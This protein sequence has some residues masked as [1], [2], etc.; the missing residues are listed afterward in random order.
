[1]PD[2]KQPSE[3]FESNDMRLIVE[4]ARQAVEAERRRQEARNESGDDDA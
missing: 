1:M 4:Q 2:H 3:D